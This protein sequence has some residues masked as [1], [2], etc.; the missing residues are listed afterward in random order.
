M[1]FGLWRRFRSSRLLRRLLQCLVYVC[2]QTVWMLPL[3]SS[4]FWVLISSSN[5]CSSKFKNVQLSLPVVV[6]PAVFSKLA[7]VTSISSCNCLYFTKF[8]VN[9]RE[10]FP[11]SIAPALDLGP[12]VRVDE[13]VLS[14]HIVGC[15]DYRPP[16]TLPASR[17]LMCLT[18]QVKH[19]TFMSVLF[20]GK[21]WC[22]WMVYFFRCLVS[23]FSVF[24]STPHT[25]ASSSIWP[26][27]WRSIEGRRKGGEDTE[28][29]AV[30]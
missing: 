25:L 28:W 17:K 5:R 12:L 19:S 26:Q 10:P 14:H 16:P 7:S 6:P 8:K 20:W 15:D 24:F 23:R 29:E 21:L 30:T 4:G 13:E 22:D 27:D 11:H 2:P 9:P 1:W 3:T 18:T